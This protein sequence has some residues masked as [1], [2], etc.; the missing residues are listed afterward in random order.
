ME[1]VNEGEMPLESY[2]LIHKNAKLSSEEKIVLADWASL[3]MKQ[4]E[5]D[6]NLPPEEKK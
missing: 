4:I 6:N 5:K 3:T 2:T 1:M